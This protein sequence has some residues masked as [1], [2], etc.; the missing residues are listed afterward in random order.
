LSHTPKTRRDT[1]HLG[2][3]SFGLSAWFS[4]SIDVENELGWDESENEQI[5]ANHSS[6]RKPGREM[7]GA[8]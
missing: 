8:G 3:L 4:T 6:H 5:I 1:A 7:C 2:G